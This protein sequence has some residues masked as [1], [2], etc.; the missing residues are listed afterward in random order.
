MLDGLYQIRTYR[1]TVTSRR[2][3]AVRVCEEPFLP[4]FAQKRPASFLGLDGHYPAAVAA[5][6]TLQS[7]D[8]MACVLCIG[9]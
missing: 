7:L 4:S 9:L 3:L 6:Y 2:D 1:S 8:A 5:C